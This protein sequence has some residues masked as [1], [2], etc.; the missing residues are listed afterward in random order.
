MDE[1]FMDE[2]FSFP[3]KTGHTIFLGQSL[4]I[5]ADK[6]GIPDKR[7]IKIIVE[8]IRIGGFATQ[9]SFIGFIKGLNNDAE[10]ITGE[11]S[12]RTMNVTHW[13]GREVK[14]TLPVRLRQMLNDNIVRDNE[15][16]LYEIPKKTL[17]FGDILYGKRYD[18]EEDK[19]DKHTRKYQVLG[20]TDKAYS[21]A[22]IGEQGVVEN[23]TGIFDIN[24]HEE[25]T[26]PT[27]TTIMKLFPTEQEAHNAYVENKLVLTVK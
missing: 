10:K 19:L 4:Y 18:K 16:K 1:V 15:P 7:E 6:D 24:T 11:F 26:Q 9:V 21:A 8:A 12:L 23:Y 13:N 20:V 3:S 5:Y 2:V 27:V 22:L 14:Y 25:I 17:K